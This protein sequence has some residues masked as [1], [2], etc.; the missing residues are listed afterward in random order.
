[1]QKTTM[2][3]VEPEPSRRGNGGETAAQRAATDRS[4]SPGTRV[5]VVVPC[6]NE[7]AVLEQLYQQVEGAAASWGTDYEVVLVDDGSSDATWAAMHDLHHRNPRWKSVRLARNFG[8]QTALRAGLHAATGNVVAVID[9]DLQDPPELLVEMLRHWETGADVIYGVRQHRKEGPFKRWAYHWFYRLLA[10]LSEIDIPVDAGDFSVMDRRVVEI[11]KRM[12]ERQPFIRALRSW[13][14]FNQVAVPY[15]RQARSA[16]RSKYGLGGLIGLALD[17]ILSS[18]IMPLRMA[19]WF[20][21]TVS[22]LAFLGAVTLLLMRVF[23]EQLRPLGFEPV[24]GSVSII[25][26]ILFLGGVQI[27]CVGILGEYIGRIYEN[28]KGRPLWTVRETCGVSLPAA[29]HADESAMGSQK[30]ASQST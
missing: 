26:S 6:Y 30:H 18:S 8:H 28:V 20:G 11:I 19:T 25:V 27:L 9:A 5:T 12:P 21:A 10:R 29:G 17:G 4:L 23:A 1:M 2:T 7:A 3:S 24:P 16:G 14:G 13:V 22:L 15:E